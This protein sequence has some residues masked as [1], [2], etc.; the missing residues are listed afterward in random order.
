MDRLD[1]GILLSS[2]A[3]TPG[4]AATAALFN[5]AANT[6]ET[7]TIQTDSYTSGTVNSTITPAGGFA[8]AACLFDNNCY[9]F[10]F[11]DTLGPGTFS[12]AL[13]VFDDT[14]VNT[15]VT[16][17]FADDGDP[18]LTCL[19]EGTSSSFCDLTTAL[20]TTPTGTYASAIT[21][22]FQFKIGLTRE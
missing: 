2:L 9:D 20:G 3:V 11:L 5:I 21:G 14:P 18:G 8:P 12:T 19:Q 10:Y 22:A 15:A 17:S 6:S 1:N 4:F 16:D 7:I 13:A